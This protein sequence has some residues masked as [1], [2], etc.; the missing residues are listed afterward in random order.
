M[1]SYNTYPNLPWGHAKTPGPELPSAPPEAPQV[2]YHLNV[3]QAKGRGL[4]AKE[5]MFKKK[6]EKYTK[7]LNQLMWL[8]A[9]S[10]GI[11][12]ATGISSVA[13]FATLI[14]APVSISL[15]VTSL[16]GVIASGITLVLTKKYQKKL[17]KVT[18]LTDIIMPA[19]VVFER[20]V[21][22]TL[23]N[24]II[25]EEEFNMLQM[26]HLET[27]NELMGIDHRMETEHRSPLKTKQ[28]HDVAEMIADI[29]KAGPLTY[30]NIFQCYNGSEF[31]GEVTK[32]LEKHGVK[33][34]RVTTKYKHTH[35]AF[36]E[37]LNKIL[38][39]RLFKVQDAQE[40]NDPERVSLRWVKH[41]YGLVDELNDITTEIIGMKP[42]D[43]I[44]LDQVPLVNREV[45]PPEDKLPE[46]G[47]YRYLL[48]PSEEHNDQRQRATDR[49]WSK[50]TYRLREIVEDA[51]NRVMFY[52]LDGPERA[53]VSE[54]LM[55]IPE[56]TELPPDYIQER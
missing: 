30:P 42:K 26:L 38:A 35:T 56:D 55:L 32:M 49:V 12:I 23:K 17:K 48:Q 52:L 4:M 14:G 40:L 20:V 54:E 50:R 3:V 8:N 27:L 25:N 13:T 11:S 47:L 19:L 28:A 6:Y 9:S 1:T 31:K 16:T 7:I 2:A 41:L 24:G 39:E 53:F 46:D 15:G 37:A 36:V 5:Q 21:S 34:Q 29:Y 18:K 45:Y 43:A 44:V 33:I 51:G 22:G 10:S